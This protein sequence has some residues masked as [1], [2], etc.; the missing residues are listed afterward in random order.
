MFPTIQRSYATVG[1]DVPLWAAWR[2][3][4]VVDGTVGTR[5]GAGQGGTRVIATSITPRSRETVP[6]A[7]QRS[8]HLFLRRSSRAPHFLRQANGRQ[9]AT[10]K[11]SRV[12]HPD[13]GA[14]P[15]FLLKAVH[16][17]DALADC[18]SLAPRQSI[19]LIP[20]LRGAAEAASSDELNFEGRVE[21]LGAQLRMLNRPTRRM[22]K[23]FSFACV[24]STAA[25]P[26]STRGSAFS[27]TPSD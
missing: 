6:P 23:R 11:A 7:R 25:V 22:N 1:D 8:G 15:A 27:S 13:W 5:K 18:R 20:A 26:V 2:F 16:R 9:Q 12:S 14:F 10:L 21:R 4:Q 3:E 19:E 17:A 24:R